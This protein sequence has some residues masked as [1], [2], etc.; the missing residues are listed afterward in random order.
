MFISLSACSG[1]IRGTKFILIYKYSLQVDVPQFS[2]GDVVRMLDDMSEVHYL[3]DGHGGWTD[4]MALVGKLDDK[5][6]L[7]W[8]NGLNYKLTNQV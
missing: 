2:V 1:N 6:I 7:A 8:D 3:Q 4:D 5:H